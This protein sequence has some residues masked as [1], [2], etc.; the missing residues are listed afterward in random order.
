VRIAAADTPAVA[1]ASHWRWLGFALFLLAAG[2]VV[3]AYL[4]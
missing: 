3:L 4:R 1:P 2:G